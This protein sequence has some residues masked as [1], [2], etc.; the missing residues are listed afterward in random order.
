M[1]AQACS[2]PDVEAGYALV[3]RFAPA[4]LSQAIC[5]E[6]GF[7]AFKLMLHAV[8]WSVDLSIGQSNSVELA[9]RPSCGRS[10]RGGRRFASKSINRQI[11]L[12]SPP[13]P[14]PPSEQKNGPNQDF[15]SSICACSHST[16]ATK[17]TQTG[18][19]SNSIVYRGPIQLPFH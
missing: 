2:S 4:D 7:S 11:Y 5:A 16:D 3:K 17:V 1:A 9:D 15:H 13:K 12:P 14:Q 19:H 8:L 10:H 6:N 18:D